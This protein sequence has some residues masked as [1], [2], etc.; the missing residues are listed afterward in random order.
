MTAV[1]PKSEL[2]AEAA[3]RDEAERERESAPPLPSPE[4]FFD[5]LKRLVPKGT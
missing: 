4:R 5:D 2:I 1:I 3:Y